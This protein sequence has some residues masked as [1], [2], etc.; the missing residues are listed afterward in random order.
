MLRFP[1]LDL[2]A[3]FATIREE[4]MIALARVMESQSFILGYQVERFETEIADV[5]GSAEAVT[6]ASGSDA[7][8]LALLAQGLQAGDEVVT[9]PFTFVATAGVPAHLGMR[10]VFVDIHPDTFNLD[11]NQIDAAISPRTRAIIPVHLFG[12][13][14]DMKPILDI[15]AQHGLAVIEDA[16]QAI[17]AHYAGKNVGSLGSA[18]CFSFFPSK[19]LGGAG[20]GGLITTSDARIAAV[21]RRLRVHGSTRKYYYERVGVN[22]R[23]DAL[24]AAILQ[25]KL[26]Y[27]PRWTEARRKNAE[28]YRTLIAQ[29]E[30]ESDIRPPT[31]S[32]NCHHVYNQF[33]VRARKRDEL[34]V[35]LTD[36]GIPTEIYYPYPLH[37]QEA[38][39]YLGYKPGQ[40]PE[41]ERASGE[42]LSLPIYPELTRDR[43]ELVVEIIAKFYT[44]HG[45]QRD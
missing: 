9:T 5:I 43:Q 19:N 42:V 38:F 12:L 17:G 6:C 22:S 39:T 26:K 2:R 34:R 33:T 14:A 35:F 11:A 40:F 18:G 24:Q 41:A 10:P 25:V 45:S 30:L 3:Q 23:L 16:A 13:P 21:L 4:V 15:A 29:H 1:F 44:Q 36:E 7:L 27:L 8:L 28:Y 31:E 20:D 32:S 37:Q